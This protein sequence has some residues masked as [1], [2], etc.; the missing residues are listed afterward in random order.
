MQPDPS[1]GGPCLHLL[2]ARVLGGGVGSVSVSVSVLPLR[3]SYVRG[4]GGADQCDKSDRRRATESSP[5]SRPKQKER[6]LRSE[7]E[8]A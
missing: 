4:A 7:V 6:L 2:V 5:S 8:G 3:C 1:G